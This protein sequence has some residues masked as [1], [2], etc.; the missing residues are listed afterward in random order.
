MYRVPCSTGVLCVPWECFAGRDFRDASVAVDADDGSDHIVSELMERV[1][2]P[3]V[4][5]R[6]SA[7]NEGVNHGALRVSP[8]KTTQEYPCVAL[9]RAASSSDAGNKAVKCLFSTHSSAASSPVSGTPMGRSSASTTTST[10]TAADVL[11]HPIP[12]VPAAGTATR[13]CIVCERLK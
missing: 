11:A 7:H 6:L 12:S 9:R 4:L 1:T 10:S 5:G 3:A 2:P 13:E 8:H